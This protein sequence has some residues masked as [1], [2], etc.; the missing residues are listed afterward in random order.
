M[1]VGSQRQT[2]LV[3]EMEKEGLSQLGITSSCFLLQI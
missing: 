2:I 1:L 3:R